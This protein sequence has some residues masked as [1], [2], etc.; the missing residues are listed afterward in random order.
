MAQIDLAGWVES[1]RDPSRRQFRQGVH[2]V[3]RAVAN[4][5]LAPQMVMKGGILLAIRYQSERFTKDVD[6]STR[7]RVQDVH[8]PSLVNSIEQALAPVSADNEYG[9]AL[10]LQSYELKPPD[11]PELSFPTLKMKIAYANRAIQKEMR[12]FDLRQ[13][14]KTVQLDYSFNE[15]ASEVE[16]QPVD[17]GTLS[18]YAYHDL[19]AEKL[20]AVL[21]QPLRKRYRFQDIY[22]LCLLLGCATLEGGDREIILRKLESASE[23]RS[24]PLSRMAMRDEQV[25][26]HS[27]REYPNVAALVATPPPPFE[28]AYEEVRQFFESL[29][30]P[31]GQAD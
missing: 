18:M 2:L 9:L 5:V 17:G 14:T 21:Q 25:L 22:D 10:G 8:I 30:W 15:W 12:R 20:R 16:N 13:S 29:P 28:T 4:S 26:E 31:E 6:F 23:D 1:E 3:L 11:R 19:I 24:V 7:Q 27:Q